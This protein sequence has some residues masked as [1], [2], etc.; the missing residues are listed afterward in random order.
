MVQHTLSAAPKTGNQ[1]I[2]DS[3][4]TSHMC[5][6]ESIFT[7]LHALSPPMYVTLGDGRSLQASGRGDIVL[8]MNLPQEKNRE[9]YLT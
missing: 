6:D 7:N 3:G 2:V 5:N 1:W 8:K 9:L 4:A